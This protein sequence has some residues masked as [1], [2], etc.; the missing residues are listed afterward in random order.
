M[1]F[2]SAVFATIIVEPI[3]SLSADLNQPSDIA[4]SESGNIIVLDGVNHR[5]VIFDKN[6]KT[7][8]KFSTLEPDIK[9]PELPMGLAID[10]QN[11]YVTQSN[12]G[13]ILVF[14][15]HGIFMRTIK[16]SVV[17][18]PEPVALVVDGNDIIWSDRRNHQIC[19]TNI[20]TLISSYCWGKKGSGKNAFHFP[21]Q[22][23]LDEQAYIYVVDILNGRIQSFNSRGQYFM[24]I[25]RSGI[26]SGELYRPNGLALDK[27]QNLYVSDSYLGTVSIFK[28]GRYLGKLLDAEGV[29]L[30][31]KS[32]VAMRVKK[33]RLYIVDAI[34]NSVEV[35]QLKYGAEIKKI[36]SR[37]VKVAKISRKNCILCHLSWSDDYRSENKNESSLLPVAS[38]AMCYSCHHG[39]IVDSRLTIGQKQ[40]HPDFHHRRKENPAEEKKRK[41][42]IPSVVPLLEKN[43]LYCGSCH[44][45]HVAEK[46]G[47]ALYEKHGNPWLRISNHDGRLCQRCHASLL[48]DVWEE[49]RPNQGINH[50]V[51]TILQAAIAANMKG[52]AKEKHLQKGLTV[53]LRKAGATLSPDDE[54]IC[55]SCHQIHGGENEALT[56]IRIKKSELCISCHPRQNAKDLTDARRKG[57][58]PVNVKLDKPVKFGDEEVN[59][60]TCLTCHSAHRGKKGTAQ[61]KYESNN[62]KLCAYCHDKYDELKNSDHNLQNSADKSLNIHR[63]TPEQSGLCGSCHSLHRANKNRPFL[64]SVEAHDYDGKE[65]ILERD[66]ICLDCHR[67]KGQAEKMVVKYFSHPRD[68]LVLRSNIEVMPLIDKDGKISEFGEVACVTCHNPHRWQSENNKAQAVKTNLA[69]EMGKNL[70]GNILTSFLRRSGVM[71]SF[72]VD[73]HGIEAKPKYKYYHDKFVRS[74]PSEEK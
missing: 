23:T 25:G 35:Y 73:C 30:K 5:I 45:P 57:V 54:M 72:C 8:Q 58:H 15:Y 71:G 40:Q 31:F 37:L 65:H 26:G 64:S 28:N 69:T 63:Q 19:R 4:I 53:N 20:R 46:N 18:D 1:S 47:G 10:T 52:Y 38:E 66:R 39:A 36:S 32:P 41:D 48:D 34:N 14:N 43:T 3:M 74:I 68:D 13:R 56:V 6:G 49:K 2:C 17:H 9:Y 55:Q 21:F 60:V 51:G 29:Q 42:K 27:R 24:P 16:L 67:K 33:G 11:I 44:D 62:G 50:P 61:L 70:D 7:I 12:P 22:L 59:F